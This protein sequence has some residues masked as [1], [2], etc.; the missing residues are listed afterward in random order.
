MSELTKNDEAKKEKEKTYSV[1]E[2]KAIVQKVKSCVKA[3]EQASGQLPKVN[4]DGYSECPF[5]EQ[6]Y[7]KKEDAQKEANACLKELDEC[8]HWVTNEINRLTGNLTVITASKDILNTTSTK[9]RVEDAEIKVAALC[10]QF[11]EVQEAIK[12]TFEET[13]EAIQK[14]SQ[15]RFP[16]RIPREFP[17][18]PII[19]DYVDPRKKQKDE[20]S[21]FSFSGEMKQMFGRDMLNLQKHE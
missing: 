3:L 5:A 19:V 18:G 21:G 8:A 15:K 14:A 12:S 7:A 6:L 1:G 9:V 2:C 16:G 17:S 10:M 11:E 4:K 13:Q 20:G